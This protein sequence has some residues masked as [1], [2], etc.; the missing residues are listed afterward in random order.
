MVWGQDADIRFHENNLY[1]GA[2]SCLIFLLRPHLM[3]ACV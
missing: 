3:Y 2:N 1:K